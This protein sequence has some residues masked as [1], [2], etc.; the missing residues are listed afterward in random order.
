VPAATPA[1]GSEANGGGKHGAR[2]ARIGRQLHGHVPQLRRDEG[3][4]TGKQMIEGDDGKPIF[5]VQAPCS[6][7]VEGDSIGEDAIKRLTNLVEI[8]F[9]AKEKN[10]IQSD[11]L[12]KLANFYTDKISVNKQRVF[13]LTLKRDSCNQKIDE[14]L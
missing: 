7:Q 4:G 13:S 3:I 11:D 6:H 12:I 10:N 8:N 2:W 14:I 9:I 5:D 1:S